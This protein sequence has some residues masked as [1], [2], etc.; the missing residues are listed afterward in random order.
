MI[1][2]SQ[3]ITNTRS[4]SVLLAAQHAVSLETKSD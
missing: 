1:T 3:K 2:K 4:P